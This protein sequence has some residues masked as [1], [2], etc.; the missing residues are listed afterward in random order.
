MISCVLEEE[1][2]ESETSIFEFFASEFRSELQ[3]SLSHELEAETVSKYTY[4]EGIVM[5]I[6]SLLGIAEPVLF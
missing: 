3:L 6:T 5:G 1:T 4:T 2:V